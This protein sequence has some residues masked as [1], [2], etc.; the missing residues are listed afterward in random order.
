M[1]IIIRITCEDKLDNALSSILKETTLEELIK[2]GAE[3]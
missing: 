1:E 2:N 3:V